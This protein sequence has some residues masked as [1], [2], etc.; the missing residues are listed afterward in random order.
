[1]GTSAEIIGSVSAYTADT[2]IIELISGA[3]AGLL[4]GIGSQFT[5][6]DTIA[7]DL[8]ATWTIAGDASGL[9]NG[10]KIDGVTSRDTIDLTGTV[11]PSDSF[12]SSTG[13]LTLFNTEHTEIGA[14]D[15][16][17]TTLLP[18]TTFA[19]TSDG[20]GG[21][22]ITTK[23]ICYLRGTRIVTSKGEMLVEDISIGDLVVTRSAGLQP[24]RWIGRQ[25][26]NRRF[27]QNNRGKIPVHIRA[28]ALGAGLPM[29]D[30]FVSPGHSMLLGEVLILARNLVNG[31][32]ITQ[33]FAR[34]GNP[35]TIEYSQMELTGHDC[36]LAE[37]SWSESFADGPG[38]RAQ[39]RNMAEYLALHPDY[40]EPAEVQLCAP[41][42]EKGAA[43]EA[44]LLPVLSL[45]SAGLSVGPLEGWIDDLSGETIAGWALDTQHPNCR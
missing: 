44:A 27:V 9:L 15:L 19:L 42:P 29:R 33:D 38:L 43:L 6:F 28:G 7:I 36:I 2:N 39:F 35:D 14:L 3:S 40:V 1:M 20:N 37:G 32:T 22:D 25:S 41:R 21:T 24:V 4:S 23:A 45:A 11:A 16:G 5:G 10:I 17:L 13:V 26:F 31:V 34:M 8:G 12:N 18:G 30:L